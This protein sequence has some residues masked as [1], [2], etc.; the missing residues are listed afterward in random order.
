MHTGHVIAW[1]N[2]K[3]HTFYAVFWVGALWILNQDY[4]R[5]IPTYDC[6]KSYN[7]AKNAYFVH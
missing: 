4:L 2:G 5:Q 6:E 1:K 3:N 7:N